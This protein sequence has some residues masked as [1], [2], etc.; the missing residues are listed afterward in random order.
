[1]AEEELVV[2]RNVRKST[3]H[4]VSAGDTMQE[5]KEALAQAS[6]TLQAASVSAQPVL[7][8]LFLS[9][10]LCSTSSMLLS[11]QVFCLLVSQLAVQ[12]IQ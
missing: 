3:A 2:R 8:L 7:V 9:A 12:C 5:I 10:C 1:M 11:Q 4:L 6:Q